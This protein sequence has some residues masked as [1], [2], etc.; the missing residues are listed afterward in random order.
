MKHV[1]WPKSILQSFWASYSRFWSLQATRFKQYITTQP[2]S[3]KGDQ[4][5]PPQP[6]ALRQDSTTEAKEH[7]QLNTPMEKMSEPK[8][9]STNPTNPTNPPKPTSKPPSRSPSDTKRILESLPA[10]PRLA[11]DLRLASTTFMQTLLKTWRPPANIERGAFIVIGRVEFLGSREVHQ[12]DV[13]AFHHPKKMT[14]DVV[15]LV[16][17]RAR[18]LRYKPLG[19]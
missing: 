4:S 18:P 17:H 11:G 15:Q 19:G 2:E 7:P 6:L 13:L 10:P 5:A 1:L 16:P 8:S 9:P 3:E 14:L 12:Y